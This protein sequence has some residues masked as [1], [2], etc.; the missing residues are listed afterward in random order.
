NVAYLMGDRSAAV[1]AL[2]KGLE[3]EPDNAL[4]RENLKR[5]EQANPSKPTASPPP[6]RR[7]R[8]SPR[9]QH[10]LQPPGSP[11]CLLPRL[12]RPRL[13]ERRT[14]VPGLKEAAVDSLLLFVGTEHRTRPDQIGYDRT[15]RDRIRQSRAGPNRTSPSRARLKQ[16]TRKQIGHNRSRVNHAC[17]N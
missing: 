10:S 13:L 12:A 1:A 14:A 11:G 7:P 16:T 2:R 4:F 9:P 17:L 15:C 6:S 8:P 3:L 5:L